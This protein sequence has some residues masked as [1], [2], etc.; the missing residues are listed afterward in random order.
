MSLRPRAPDISLTCASERRNVSLRGCGGGV[1]FAAATQAT[2]AGH[3]FACRFGRWLWINAAT[4]CGRQPQLPDRIAT[5]AG[6]LRHTWRTP[7]PR[8]PDRNRA[9]S[10]IQ[11]RKADRKV[12]KVLKDSEDQDLTYPQTP[13]TKGRPASV[14]I[15]LVASS[16]CRFHLQARSEPTMP[17]KPV[18]EPT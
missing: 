5:V 9:K 18:L 13:K 1:R 14:A 3:P 16:I 12:S 11:L 6:P 2:L 15:T 17:A 10:L 7:L 4:D 8:L